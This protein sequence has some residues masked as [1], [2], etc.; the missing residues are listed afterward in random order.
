MTYGPADLQRDLAVPRET[1]ERLETHRR[2]LEAWSKRINLIGPRELEDYWRRHAL[3]C[4]QLPALAP[5]ARTWID[6]GAGAGFPGVVVACVLADAPGAHVTLVET[7]AKKAAFLREAIRETGAPARVLNES[8]DDVAPTA[9][10]YDVVTARAFAPLP[11]IILSA[12][13][14]LDRG[15]IGLFPKGAEYRAEI[16]AAADQGWTLK[17]DALPSR[18]D[19]AGR[20]LRI[21]GAT[22]AGKSG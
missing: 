12:K 6:I 20:I 13:P 3:D 5:D 7:N 8:I 22:R 19:P 2:L 18:S 4:A 10:P 14:I 17:V 11:R 1:C 21:E 16:A 15:A 9:E